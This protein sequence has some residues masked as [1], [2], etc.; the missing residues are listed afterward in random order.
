MKPQ[1][2][3]INGLRSYLGPV[4]V[5]FTGKNLVAALGDTGAGKSSLLEAITFA[6]FRKS[7]WD[8]REPRQLIADGVQAMSV[9]LTFLHE[10]QRWRVH[11]TLHATNANAGRNH[12]ENLDTGEEIDNAG[13]VDTR[14]R[15]LLQMGYETFLRVGLLPQ[16][17]FDQLLT[18]ATKA[19][20]ERLR[21]L[22]GAESLEAVR[23]MATRQRETLN[24]LLATA[25]AKRN[26]MPEDPEQ[27]AAEAGRAADE[28]AAQAGR[29]TT[30]IDR[31]TALRTEAAD[32]QATATRATTAAHT[33]AARA[34]T[35]A[36][37]VLDALEAVATDIAA[38][39]GELERRT[40]EAADEE[41]ELTAAIGEAQRQGEGRDDL[42]KAA[43][44]LQTFAADAA[45]N[46][47][48]RDRLAA[49]TAELADEG[50]AIAK[51]EAELKQHAERIEPFAD[52]I[53]A[54]TKTSDRIRVLA[55]TA[56]TDTGLAL[57]A[58]GRVADTAISCDAATGKRASLAGDLGRLEEEATAT[59]QGVTNAEA[60]RNFL[61]LR[62]RAAALAAELHP[63]DDCL[64]CRQQVPADF[65]PAS[66]TDAA[67]LAAA[68]AELDAANATH[69]QARDRLAQGRADVT[70][71]EQAVR[72]R[73]KE[74]QDAQA[75]AQEAT[76]AA[77]A[78]FLALAALAG[79]TPLPF[80]AEA[81]AKALTVATTAVATST[82]DSAI[83]PAPDTAAITD[84][85][86][87]CEQA[88][89]QHA[90]QL[91]AE[92]HCRTATIKADRKTLD[93]RKISHQRT[94][95]QATADATRHT[96]AVAKT[97]THAST[98]PA[99]I[100]ALLP[101]EAIDVTADQATA[102]TE[103]VTARRTEVESLHTRRET[104][105]TEKTAIL[106]D[107]RALDRE[108]DSGLERPLNDLRGTLNTWAEAADQANTHLAPAD[109]HDTPQP[110]TES[111]IADIRQY[112]TDL[113]AITT[114]LGDQLAQLSTLSTDRATAAHNSLEEHAAALA[115]IE[116][117]DSA[118]DLT[119]P[120]ALHPLVAARTT[121]ANQADEQ[122]RRQ[123]EAQDLIKPAADL[124]YAINAGHARH[125][126][127]EILRRELV[128][129][130]F[131]GHLTMQRTRALL[132][133]ASDLLGQMSDGRFGFAD[134]F[135][136]VSRDSG[137]VHHPNRLSGGEKFL[138]S[139]AL[140]L[141]L[142]EL[143][144]RSGPSLGSLFLDEGFA[145]LDTTT[146]DTALEVL[147]AQ[148]GNDRLVMVI[149]HLHAVAEAVDD[150]L[151]VERTATGSSA[152]WL[153]PA[154]RDALVQADVTSGLQALAR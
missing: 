14:I 6:L 111:R 27:A 128:D 57:S 45:E 122:R 61:Q 4:T 23:D 48:E 21:E 94:S 135:E 134:T 136:I 17:K 87:A 30:A 142:A 29:L 103:A 139:L 65:E 42:I 7:S 37:T 74:H 19:R 55:A 76:A 41:Q 73:D 58:A 33:L 133:V 82:T 68:K 132:G 150:V 71:A 2:L 38:R 83:R 67:E 9:E 120:E 36:G 47:H 104:Y 131:L 22:F 149:S 148:A 75:K 98:L 147:R 106:A 153:T 108:A 78:S 80:D 15:A 77:A 143:H 129:A 144:A 99:R 152:R 16:G 70:S 113:T 109:Q 32:A 101:G 84:A 56:R 13:A 60:R 124:T 138:A 118:T 107:Q 90:E 12:L 1:T 126:A 46:R 86:T 8:A 140:A 63:G 20:T 5:D 154:E 28:A 44:I 35:D 96:R 62:D 31:M 123:R 116:A 24:D 130:K 49:L 81:A 137:V 100:R 64:V 92:G 18:A 43:L 91:T 151:W 114:A 119:T 95:T 53:R 115:D 117:F 59:E 127:L 39:R 3:L 25:R 121:A 66:A 88:A 102:A 145:A 110:P 79:E 105:R 69:R 141:A 54:A 125:D 40:R 146:L 85:I 52:Q 72:E 34:V 93:E 51:D 50:D 26:A 112:A 97:A 11:R 89:S 10:G